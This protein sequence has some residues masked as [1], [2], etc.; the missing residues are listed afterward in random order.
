MA[1]D[2]QARGARQGSCAVVGAAIL[3]VLAASA[4]QAAAPRVLSLDQ[5]A[6]QYLL[7]LS[8]RRAIVGL[9]P[10]ADD[11]DSLLRGQAGGLPRRRGGLESILA[12]RPQVVVRYW[13]GDPRLTAALQARGVDVVTINEAADFPAVRADIRRVAAHLGQGEAGEALVAQMDVRLARAAGAWRGKRAIYL[14]PAGATAGPGTL[15]D[16]VLRAAGLRNAVARPGYGMLSLETL[17]L[18]PPDAAVLGFFDTFQLAG[19]SWGP[20]GHRILRKLAAERAIASLPGAMLSCP[21]W[22]AAQ[23]VEKLAAAAPR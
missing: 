14:T 13:G 9:S 4:A 15:M 2:R 8:P 5:C 3:A 10:R 23:A 12:A 6:D 21:S 7:A 11:A 16:A 18:D 17:A 1:R 20:G 22:A 19:D